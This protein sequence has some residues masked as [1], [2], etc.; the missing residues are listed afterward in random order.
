[1]TVAIRA[2]SSIQLNA[3]SSS[4]AVNRLIGPALC[5][6]NASAVV[7]RMPSGLGRAAEHAV[8][9]PLEGDVEPRGGESDRVEGPACDALRG[10]GEQGAHI[11]LAQQ[12]VNVDTTDEPFDV[13]LVEEGVEVDPLQD[14]LHVDLADDRVEGDHPE[15]SLDW[16]IVCL[17]SH[18][19][20]VPDARHSHT[21]RLAPAPRSFGRGRRTSGMPSPEQPA[22]AEPEQ[23]GDRNHEEDGQ[24][25]LAEDEVDRHL[26]EVGE[27]KHKQHNRKHP[28]RDLT[29][30]KRSWRR[31]G[32]GMTPRPQILLKA[33]SVVL[34]TPHA[35]RAPR[36]RVPRRRR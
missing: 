9:P 8:D 32:V 7:S 5:P 34:Q 25:E 24:R 29:S 18:R 35:M 11:H 23:G 28:A 1:M 17:L 10:V 27:R 13:D 20:I 22:D 4:P 36:W 2:L 6:C 14:G 16:A 21:G 19:A 12:L 3:R 30:G 31:C 33:P 15:Q 26:L